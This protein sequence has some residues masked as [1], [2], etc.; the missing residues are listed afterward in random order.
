MGEREERREREVEEKEIR[1]EKGG[2]NGRGK[3][4]DKVDKARGKGKTVEGGEG[5][6]TAKRVLNFSLLVHVTR[7][8]HR[9]LALKA[10]IGPR[11]R[12]AR[13]K[14]KVRNGE[15]EGMR[16][17]AGKGRKRRKEEKW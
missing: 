13:E 14:E 2:G 8:W 3:E 17:G 9:C 15:R 5:S 4:V 16:V 10:D 12:P 7:Q 11:F 1:I 6:A